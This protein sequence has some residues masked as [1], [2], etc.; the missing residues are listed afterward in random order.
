MNKMRLLAITLFAAI[1]S[2]V[3]CQ[4]GDRDMRIVASYINSLS[5][6]WEMGDTLVTDSGTWTLSYELRL[7]KDS[8]CYYSGSYSFVS[9]DERSHRIF[10][11]VGFLGTKWDVG[12][13]NN[14]HSYNFLYLYTDGGEI[15][16]WRILKKEKDTLIT[17]PT[18]QLLLEMLNWPFGQR[19][20][21]K[22]IKKK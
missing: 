3:Y 14:P 8:A 1:V 7:H 10:S 17:R 20:E 2:V 13:W 5:G 12:N 4:V 9:K 16:S 22:W 11:N 21:T 6:N 18:G 15:E 19:K